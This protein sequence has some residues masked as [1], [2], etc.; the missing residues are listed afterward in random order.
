MNA[1]FDTPLDLKNGWR[2]VV[3]GGP[4]VW[5]DDDE[6][7]VIE[8]VRIQTPP[9]EVALSVLSVTVTPDDDRWSLDVTSSGKKL[10]PGKADA[11]AHVTVT[12][13]NG[14]HDHPPCYN[15]VQLRP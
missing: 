1:Q 3:A 9:G 2:T 7:A 13:K 10:T 15:D 4:C 14:A 12:K 5:E 8:N 11:Y 6:S